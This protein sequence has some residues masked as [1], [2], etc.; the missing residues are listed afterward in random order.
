MFCKVFLR[1]FCTL[2]IFFICSYA[3]SIFPSAISR[4]LLSGK[5]F[6]TKD[7]TYLSRGG[8]SKKNNKGKVGKSDKNERK[9]GK[10]RNSK[11]VK[12]VVKEEFSE[13]VIDDIIDDMSV[14]ESK[15]EI[16]EP[17]A[18]PEETK[19]VDMHE[20]KVFLPSSFLFS[21]SFVPR[22]LVKLI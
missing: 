7:P 12:S 19:P 22:N 21:L 2:A 6:H 14:D 13:E 5:H 11:K 20:T 17:V 10:E 1:I 4:L 9:K 18:I 8:A 15:A 16:E 3:H